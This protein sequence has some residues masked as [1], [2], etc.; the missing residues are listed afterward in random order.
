MENKGKSRREFIRDLTLTGSVAF[1]ASTPWL[2]VLGGDDSKS[3][4]A[5]NKVRVA[6]I[7]TG[8]RGMELMRNLVPVL[9]ANN[10]EICALC[11]NFPDH[12]KMAVDYCKENG[13]SPKAYDDHRKLIEQAKPDGVII[14][15]PLTEHTH[16]TVDC[17]TAGIHTF[18]EKAMAR[19]IEDVKKMYDTHVS[20]GKI[21]QIGH[22]RLFNPIYLEGM[23]RIHGGDIGQ[24]GQIRAY[25][26]R[27][28]NWR[29]PLPNND[30]SLEKKINW[31]LY[32]EL[33]AGLLTEL[34]SH[35]IHV[36]CWALGQNPVSVMGTASTV[37]WK[38]GRTVPDNIAIIFSYPNGVQCVYDSM[39]SNKKYGLE[40]QIL[41][42]KGTIEF[43]VNRHYN[44]T[45]PTAPGIR[46]LVNDIEHGVFDKI[47]VAGSSWV[48]ETAVTYKG[49]KIAPKDLYSDTQLELEAFV[50]F[51][52]EGKVP[53]TMVKDSYYG[54]IWTLL[55][56][57]AIDSGQKITLPEGFA[58]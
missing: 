28:N 10:A 48:P 57:T 40:E 6:F 22:Q 9:A 49:E 17:L 29:R 46:Q 19:T 2:S 33:S 55:A 24:I 13:L 14:A 12:L 58:V 20:T 56:E 32:K 39:I 37:F 41:G 38:D 31:R 42:H 4:S 26:H 27:N 34:M 7:G 44:E 1:L 50:K 15:T 8:S 30:Q 45:I 54:S 43:E 36:A 16:I 5:G 3:K 21:L 52:R 35:Q 18:C 53:E 11:D 51:I 25:W 47:N 23:K